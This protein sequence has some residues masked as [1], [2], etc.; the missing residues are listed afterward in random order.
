MKHLKLFEDFSKDYEYEKNKLKE[1]KPI[2]KTMKKNG[3]IK[4][5]KKGKKYTKLF[6]DEN[7]G[8]KVYSDTHKKIDTY[9]LA[10]KTKDD[11][12]EKN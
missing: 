10:K 5:D 1:E 2:D 3:F 4:V 7:G 9:P 12:E 11:A 8:S 6:R